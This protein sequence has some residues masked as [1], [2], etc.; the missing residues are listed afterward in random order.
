VVIWL[1]AVL[2]IMAVALFVAAPLTDHA[3][4]G[5][6][7][8]EGAEGENHD[9]EHGLAIQA[10]RELDFDHAMGKLDGDDYRVLR[11]TLQTRA[12]ATMAA[13]GGTATSASAERRTEA[14]ALSPSI[15]VGAAAVNFCVQCG[16]RFEQG[17]NFCANC[18]AGRGMTTAV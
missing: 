11:Q 6:V 2:M 8:G 12:L 5:T 13:P 16:A 15:I 10:L 7:L 18:G 1:A 17:Y 14:L 3:S 4:N 9:R